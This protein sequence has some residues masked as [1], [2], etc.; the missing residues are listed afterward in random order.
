M[1][2]SKKSKIISSPPIYLIRQT[3]NSW[4][5]DRTL[6]LG[7]GIAYY[8]VFAIVPIAT[9]MVG[10]AAYFF[11][12]DSIQSFIND[13]LSNILGNEFSSAL[14]ELAQ[15]FNSDSTS[16][17]FFG[18][19]IL[20]L[21]AL[22]I[23]ASFIFI[24]LQDALDA[25]WHN[26]IRKG[27][28]KWILRYLTAYAVVMITS[29][30]LFAGLLVNTVSSIAEYIIPGNLE[31]LENFAD[32]VFSVGSI[33]VGAIVLALIY[34]LLIYEKISWSI[35]ILSSVITTLL[36]IVGTILLGY[37]LS[38]YAVTSISGAVGALLLIMVWV[39]YEAQIILVGGQFIKVLNQNK[40]L[41]PR[42][43]QIY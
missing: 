38:N 17:V 18:S 34:K 15:K 1:K 10:F 32:A 24:A 23:S 9:L 28:R 37:Y 41:L 8:G 16:T 2:N 26:P 35:L 31:I 30:L 22:F 6:R 12:T 40:K 19:N 13:T 14:A 42:F 7:A 33:A 20:G 3:Y 25:I 36:I 27:W 5:E 43:M 11:S 39:Y 29:M 4:K 21:V